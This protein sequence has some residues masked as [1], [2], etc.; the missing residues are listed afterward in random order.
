MA[1]SLYESHGSTGHHHILVGGDGAI[2][3][4]CIG[5]RTSKRSPKTCKH[6]TAY[7]RGHSDLVYYAT[8]DKFYLIWSEQAF[9]NIPALRLMPHFHAGRQGLWTAPCPTCPDV[10]AGD[11]P[12][13]RGGTP[14]LDAA[15]A[16][17]AR[18]S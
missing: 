13:F 7:C 9:T 2:Y 12:A 1:V 17:L 6:L 18:L 15:R 10:Y 16:I 11:H 4:D 5:W 14:A 8:D 3:C